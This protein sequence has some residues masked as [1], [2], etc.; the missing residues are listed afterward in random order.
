MRMS[1]AIGPYGSGDPVETPKPLWGS[2]VG[3]RTLSSTLSIL[4]TYT[5]TVPYVVHFSSLMYKPLYTSD[6]RCVTALQSYTAIHRYT[7]LYTNNLSTSGTQVHPAGGPFAIN[8]VARAGSAPPYDQAVHDEQGEHCVETE[9]R[10]TFIDFDK[11]VP[12]DQGEQGGEPFF[13]KCDQR[14]HSLLCLRG[15]RREHRAGSG[16]E[17]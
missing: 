6:T 9:A 1:V 7:S 2:P 16:G 8:Q 4:L 14:V 17:S 11:A 12:D 5:Y 13:I 15:Q 10:T 3:A